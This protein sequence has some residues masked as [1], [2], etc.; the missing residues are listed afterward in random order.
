MA[1]KR[2]F[3]D[4]QDE[5]L[6]QEIAAM[7]TFIGDLAEKVIKCRKLSEKL[8]AELLSTL[9]KLRPAT[10]KKYGLQPMEV[11]AAEG[12]ALLHASMGSS[13]LG[14]SAA[15]LPETFSHAMDDYMLVSSYILGQIP[16]FMQ[17][18]GRLLPGTNS[19]TLDAAQEL[20][21]FQEFH[22][23]SRERLMSILA[24]WR[25]TRG[26]DDP[27]M[28]FLLAEILLSM[29]CGQLA[30]AH[31]KSAEWGVQL[32]AIFVRLI[33]LRGLAEELVP[34]INTGVSD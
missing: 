14:R 7:K 28:E 11:K 15:E 18:P 21:R 16:S 23:F 2:S 31:G 3:D 20:G 32:R 13:A 9:Q 5:E 27:Q 6:S 26:V 22:E 34:F 1:D 10:A 25:D 17:L 33:S 24:D 8:A 19:G 30:I 29:L 4:P 12:P